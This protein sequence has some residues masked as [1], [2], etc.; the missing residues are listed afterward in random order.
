MSKIY[1]E[2]KETEDPR[3]LMSPQDI[4]SNIV[5]VFFSYNDT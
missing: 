1:K 5:V 2:M 3:V 4:A